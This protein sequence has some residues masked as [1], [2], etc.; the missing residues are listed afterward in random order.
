[1]KIYCCTAGDK[2][3][4]LRTSLA[5]KDEM[6]LLKMIPVQQGLDNGSLT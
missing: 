4:I 5:K 1:M 3:K 6:K 2:S